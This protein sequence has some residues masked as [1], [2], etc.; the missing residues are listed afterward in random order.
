MV[1]GLNRSPR[2]KMELWF[3]L[4]VSCSKQ[5]WDQVQSGQRVRS[6]LQ[7]RV[8]GLVLTFRKLHHVFQANLGYPRSISS[9]QGTEFFPRTFWKYYVLRISQENASL[10]HGHPSTWASFLVISIQMKAARA[11]EETN[12]GRR[13]QQK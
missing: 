9:F 13:D 10:H 5:D 6:C 2:S 1:H 3:G 4:A 8:V 7:A 12:V 11:R